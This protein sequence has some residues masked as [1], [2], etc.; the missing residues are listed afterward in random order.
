VKIS[1]RAVLLADTGGVVDVQKACADD[2]LAVAEAHVR[3]WQVGYRGL[4]AQDYLEALRPEER[5]SR[6]TFDHMNPNGPFTLVAVDG[7]AICGLV[8]TGKSRDDDSRDAGEVWAIYVDP[9]RWGAGVG[10]SLMAAA[11]SQL[12]RARY[13]EVHFGCWTVIAALG[14]ST[15]WADGNATEQNAPMSSAEPPCVRFGT[16][17]RFDHP[18]RHQICLVS[19]ELR[20]ITSCLT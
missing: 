13:S 1:G 10:R 14:G 7:D 11:V 19:R 16:H 4:I 8:T 9:R 17:A 2:R 6:Y 20:S 12:R 5:A 18:D 15:N 3:A